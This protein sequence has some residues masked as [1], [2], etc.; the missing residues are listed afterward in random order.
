[1]KMKTLGLLVLMVLFATGMAMAQTDILGAHNLGG[2][3]CVGCHAPHSGSLG[4]GITSKNGDPQNGTIALWG[5]D[6]SPLFGGVEPFGGGSYTVTLPSSGALS[7]SDPTTTSILFCL[8]CHDG[9]V[10]KG[11]MMTGW[12]VE[13]LPIFGGKAPTLLGSATAAPGGNVANG[14]SNDHPV[15]PLALVG[16]NAAATPEQ[17]YNWDCTGGASY[18]PPVITGGVITTP[19]VAAT[20]VVMNGTN[21]KQFLIDNP[22]SFW[23]SAPN[24]SGVVNPLS[25]YTNLT[26]SAVVCTT[27]HNQHSMTSWSN[28]KGTY[29]TMFF[30]KGQYTPSTGGDSVAQFCRN[31]HGGESNEMNGVTGVV[32]N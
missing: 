25:T 15:G 19:A 24:H 17:G 31:C 13:T 27:C 5:E 3:G 6:V 12:T 2:R 8:S 30:I 1:M 20:P 23:N 10:A 22:S 14:Y 9:N 21:S 4:N 32:T 16:C 11:G 28:T 29:T 7:S 18:V 26:V